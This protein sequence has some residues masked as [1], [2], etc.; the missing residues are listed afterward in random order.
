[1]AKTRS[2]P[3]LLFLVTEDWYFCSHRLPVARA[4]R[5]AGFQ[6]AVATRVREHGEAIRAE[7]FA[8]HKLRWKRRGDGLFGHLR[9]LAEIVRLYRCER[10]DIL[11]H[12]ALKPVLFGALAARIASIRRPDVV[13][14][15]M[16]LGIEFT[17]GAD[18][19]KRALGWALRL[20]IGRGRIVVQN[21]ENRD[22]L[23]GCGIDSSRI[24][25]IPGSGVDTEH[26]AALSDPSESPVAVALV[27]RMLRSKGVLDAIAAV[28]NL[29]AEGLTIALILAG[30]ADPDSRDSLSTAELAALGREA[31]IEWRGHVGDVRAVWAR[32]AVALLPSSYGEGVPKALLEAASCGRPIIASDM[33][34]CREVV[35]AGETGFLVPPHDI[36]A[37]AEAIAWLARD[38]ALRRQMGAAGRRRVVAGFGEEMVAQQTVAL[39]RSMLDMGDGGG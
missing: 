38:P 10:P 28:R 30:A 13:S 1:V 31:G 27:G 6:V 32:A 8:L 16:G 21:P 14:A 35:T 15:V 20:A 4:A 7:G 12:V 24:A 36:A 18:W 11:Y 2:Q 5:A 17:G 26:F 34:G 29:R 9:A 39:L 19:R 22:A 3:K 25:L 37:L 23:I 33:P